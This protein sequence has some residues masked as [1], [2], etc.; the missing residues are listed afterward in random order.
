MGYLWDHTSSGKPAWAKKERLVRG[1]KLAIA[2]MNIVPVAHSVSK[3]LTAQNKRAQTR[4]ETRLKSEK[5][6]FE[7]K[8]TY[9]NKPWGAPQRE[10]DKLTAYHRRLFLN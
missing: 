1:A 8:D 5:L 6:Y 2:Q 9:G 3:E 4:Y 7:L 10:V